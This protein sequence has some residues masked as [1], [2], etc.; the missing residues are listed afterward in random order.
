[1]NTISWLA[2]LFDSEGSVDAE[3][4][5]VRNELLHAHAIRLAT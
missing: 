5:A 1:M 4:S 2:F 3:S